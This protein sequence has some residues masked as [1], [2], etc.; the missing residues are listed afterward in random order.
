MYT[1]VAAYGDP[2]SFD[3]SWTDVDVNQLKE[4]PCNQIY[5]LYTKLYLTL[6]SD[7][8]TND[9]HVDY[10]ALEKQH[11]NNPAKLKDMLA[12]YG[13]DTLATI[14]KIQKYKQEHVYYE[15]LFRAGYKA[16]LVAPLSHPSSIVTPEEKTELRITRRSTNMQKFF[17]TCMVSVNGYWHRTD[18]DGQVVYVPHAGESVLKSKFNTCGITSFEKIGNI[19]QIPITEDIIFKTENE[20]FISQRVYFDLSKYDINNKTVLAVIGGY[21]Y[22]PNDIRQVSNTSY[23]LDFS[24]V[25]LLQRYFESLRYL[26][27]DYLGM[28]R[29]IH[30]PTE[31]NKP[32]FFSDEHFTKYL[33]MPQSFLVVVDT[34]SIRVKKHYI[35]HSDLPG[36]FTAYTEPKYPL[37]TSTGKLSEYWKVYEDGHWCINVNDAWWYNRQASSIPDKAAIS[38]TD[39]N[40]PYRTYY[41]SKGYLL[42]IVADTPI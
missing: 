34:P 37:V 10:A 31:I 28:S 40:M 27:M 35:K 13:S 30:N 5:Q 32:E 25:P 33:T 14:P 24:R 20:S 26:N 17:D 39:A 7:A 41:N 18:T 16:E 6:H 19:K 36:M 21:L 22:L 9:I 15:D 23:L 4:L 29:Y 1:L 2:A 42:D 3:K 11:I 38:M 8:L 12:N